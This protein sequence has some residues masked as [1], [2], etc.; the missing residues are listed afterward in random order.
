VVVALQCTRGLNEGRVNFRRG[1]GFLPRC[2]SVKNG[3]A[4]ACPRGGRR[5]RR[6]R[7]G[8]SVF[9]P[10]E[11]SGKVGDASVGFARLWVSR[12]TRGR[13]SWE[14]L[15]VGHEI[16]EGA[17]VGNRGVYGLWV[18][19]LLKWNGEELAQ[20]N[21][22]RGTRVLAL[23]REKRSKA[24][25]AEGRCVQVE[26]TGCTRVLCGL[27]KKGGNGRASACLRQR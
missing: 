21:E 10:E 19:L 24:R 6:R 17:L 12:G 25:G 23:V 1:K 22:G 4:R 14:K 26:A 2:F 16:L 27:S 5:R 3:T 9:R 15:T 20:L 8:S 13:R 11:G 18:C 7:C